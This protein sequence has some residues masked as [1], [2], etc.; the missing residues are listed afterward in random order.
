MD[1]AAF[2]IVQVCN[3]KVSAREESIVMQE[4]F[5]SLICHLNTSKTDNIVMKQVC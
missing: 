3:S 1:L 4:T 2:C 5:V